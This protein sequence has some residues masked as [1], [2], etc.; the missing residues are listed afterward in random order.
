MAS[1]SQISAIVVR[2]A[3]PPRPNLIFQ[4]TLRPLFLYGTLRAMP[5]LAWALTGDSRNTHTVQSLVKPAVLRGYMRFSLHGKDYPALIKHDATS[6]VD[7]LLLSPQSK[8][9]RLKLDDFEGELYVA[10]KIQVEVG[11]DGETV[12]ADVYLWNGELDAVSSD[13]WELETF[14]RERLE[15]WIEIFAGIELVGDSGP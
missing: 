2:H 10:T 15:D 11:E 3:F 12:D 4:Q 7:G 5:L 13:Q 8:A 1:T 6:S 14:T 9:Q